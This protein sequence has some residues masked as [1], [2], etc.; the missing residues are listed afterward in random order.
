MDAE[1]LAVDT[2]KPAARA[3]SPRF[4]HGDSSQLNAEKEITARKQL[5]LT[6]NEIFNFGERPEPLSPP[7]A[8]RKEGLLRVR[9]PLG[10]AP[11]KPETVAPPPPPPADD[12][13]CTSP[14][15]EMLMRTRRAASPPRLL[16]AASAMSPRQRYHSNMQS[17]F[18][19]GW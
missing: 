13:R 18:K 3:S 16:Q 19:V 12:L 11:L 10:H 7:P 17:A 14:R 2:V 9:A 8:T 4:Y 5:L 6:S 1:A 15:A